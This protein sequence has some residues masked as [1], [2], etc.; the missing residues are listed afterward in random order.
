MAHRGPGSWLILAAM[1]VILLGAGPLATVEG[2]EKDATPASTSGAAASLDVPPS[3]QEVVAL[4]IGGS[5]INA[6]SYSALRGPDARRQLVVSARGQ[7]GALRDATQ[8]AVFAASPAGIVRIDS[9]GLV[10]P[11]SDGKVTVTAEL[12]DPRAS[13]PNALGSTVELIVEG[14]SQEL[15]V[16]F[17]NQ[18]VP[19]FTKLGCNGGGCHGKSGGQNGFRL[20]LLGFVPEDDYEYLV[21][22]GRG[23]RHFG[24][25]PER[26]LLLQKATNIAPHGGGLRIEP[27]S[28]EHRLLERWMRQGMPYGNSSDPRV[29]RIE[30][31][32][33]MRSMTRIGRQQL[34]VFARYT[35]GSMEDVTRIAQF[36]SN[37]TEMAD[38]SVT[39]LVKTL[40]LAGDVAIMVRYQ[41]QVG[42]FRATIPLGVEVKDLPPARNFI[43]E[44]V[45]AKL[46]TLGI[47]PSA[48]SDDATFLRRVTVDIAGRTPSATEAREFLESKEPRKRDLWIDRLLASTDYAD[49]FANKWSAVLRNRRTN[50]KYTRG[51][52]AFHD[53]I[54]ESFHKNVPYDG[55]VRS[56]VAAS[57]TVGSNPPVVW[58]RSVKTASEQVEDTAQLFL[59]L[60]IQCARCHHHPFERWSQNDYYSFSAFFSRVGRKKGT[61]EIDDEPRIFHKRGVARDTNPRT[62]EVLAPRGLGAAA[63]EPRPDEDPRLL[64]ADWMS[65]PENPFFAP[66]LVNRYWKHF[67]GR[68]IVEPEDDMRLTNPATNPELL[69]ALARH[70][71]ESKFDLKDLVRTI[72]QSTAYQLL[73]EPN[74]HNVGDKRNFSRYYPK[75]LNAE[76]LYDAVNRV[77]GSRGGFAG[78]PPETRAVQLPDS[79]PA[80][81]FLTVFG[82]PEADSSCE[83][84][85]SQEA[86]LAQSLH[87]LNS[88]DL[89]GKLSEGG[90]RAAALAKDTAR[91]P[92]EKVRELYYWVYSRPPA[93]EE[94]AAALA[95]LQKSKEAQAAYED[96]AWALL[97]TKEFLF[98]H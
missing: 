57:G 54:R 46:K 34:S 90:G 10:T 17:P 25:S 93:P 43:D 79:G 26:S 94:L 56:I 9:T 70:F 92:E 62:G 75:R 31:F 16:S 87:L 20:S 3:P 86:N 63:V 64:L 4:E 55:F 12:P 52:Y 47:P 51:T 19:I 81:Y 15:P 78:L 59:G 71:M 73:S 69:G 76:V 27:G 2:G 72:C 95:H 24:A 44:L 18:I 29:E 88:K 84:E 11:L 50:A 37:D 98:N 13:S 6:P 53:W 23:R 30:V 91:S 45:F 65:G 60:R 5:E 74:E 61:D 1:G 48:V 28:H 89:H 77:T 68:G 33:A 35:D 82:K 22:E 96:I 83:C 80:N 39:G 66:A 49:F 41:G 40:D 8:E 36:E 7:S 67:F 14:F 58:Y 42:V 97:N 21:K 85:R 38:V 32:P